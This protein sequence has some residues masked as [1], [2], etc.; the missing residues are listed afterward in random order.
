MMTE[1]E[2]RIAHLR[3][4]VPLTPAFLRIMSFVN[5]RVDRAQ[6]RINRDLREERLHAALVALDGTIKML[7]E[8]PDWEQRTVC[9]PLNPAEGVR[10]EPYEEGDWFIR[11]ADLDEWYPTKAELRQA[12]PRAAAAAPISKLD[13]WVA[14]HGPALTGSRPKE[15]WNKFYDRCRDDCDGWADK[16]NG[17]PAADFSNKTIERRLQ[18]AGFK[19]KPDK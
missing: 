8:G 7:L 12:R 17:K 2:P 11:R 10:V 18:H 1:A 15:G 16:K 19:P 5:G 9:A 3:D 6:A 14:K 4:W 13:T